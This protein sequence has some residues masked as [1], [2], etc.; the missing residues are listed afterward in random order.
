MQQPT[1][2]P[3]ILNKIDAIGEEGTRVTDV[4]PDNMNKEELEATLL[5]EN[6]TV[7]EKYTALYDGVECQHYRLRITREGAFGFAAADIDT[8]VTLP[9]GLTYKWLL[10]QERAAKKGITLES[11][12]KLKRL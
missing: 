4:K 3:I 9:D 5:Q 11:P 12:S 6:V 2:A 10:L 8:C 7:L 1:N